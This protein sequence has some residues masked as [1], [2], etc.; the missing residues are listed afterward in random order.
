MIRMSEREREKILKITDLFDN[1]LRKK[2]TKGYQNF[3]W[4]IFL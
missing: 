1:R 4:N 2:E 3:D